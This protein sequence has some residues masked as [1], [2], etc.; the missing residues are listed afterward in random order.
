MAGILKGNID[1]TKIPKNKIYDG[2]KGKYIGVVISL[3]NEAD[4]FGQH[5]SITVDQTKEER[6]AKEPKIYL[7]NLQVVWTDGEPIPQK[8]AQQMPMQ[9]ATNNSGDD[10]LPF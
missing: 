6:D 4:Q 7:G 5:G 2:K 9:A 10:D 1:V 8:E 3:N